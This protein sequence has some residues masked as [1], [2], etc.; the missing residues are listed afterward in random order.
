[1]EDKREEQRGWRRR[2]ARLSQRDQKLFLKLGACLVLGLVLMG[3]AQGQHRNEDQGEAGEGP[4]PAVLSAGE[5]ELEARLTALLS[6][7]EGAGQVSVM[8]LYEDDGVSVYA[9]ERDSSTESDG[10]SSSATDSSSLAL[11]GD[12]PVLLREEQ[13]AVRGVAVLAEG[14]G[15]PLVRERLYQAV[16]SLLGINADQIAIIEKERSE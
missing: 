6:Q 12:A 7:V 16:R 4:A 5:A 15:N 9:T 14:A 10:S 1:M 11:A 8:L 13:P 3:W 2:W